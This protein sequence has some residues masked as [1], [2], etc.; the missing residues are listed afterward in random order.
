MKKMSKVDTGEYMFAETLRPADIEAGK[1]VVTK[2][3]EIKQIV[4]KYGDK[5]VAVLETGQQIFLNA[6]TLQ[7]LVEA[8][9]DE[10]EEWIGKEITLEVEV[11]ERTQG[12]QAIVVTGKSASTEEKVE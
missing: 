12:K 3:T 2:I 10:T 5:R 11:S 9:G 4:T 8:F 1:K 7:N 6:M